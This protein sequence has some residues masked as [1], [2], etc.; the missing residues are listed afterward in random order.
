MTQPSDIS[1]KKEIFDH[2]PRQN[3]PLI[4]VAAQPH[5]S[6]LRHSNVPVA[7]FHDECQLYRNP[8][9][10]STSSPSSVPSI[11]VYQTSRR[12]YCCPCLTLLQPKF[13]P[14][15]QS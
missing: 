9:N 10:Q 5:R 6:R 8:P 14:S 1:W 3:A 7:K 11:L 12:L 15:P 2:Q 13:P 4:F